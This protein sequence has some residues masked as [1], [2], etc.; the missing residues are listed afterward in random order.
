MLGGASSSSS[1]SSSL[2]GSDLPSLCRH[3]SQERLYVNAEKKQLKVGS[4][5]RGHFSVPL[6]HLPLIKVIPTQEIYWIFLLSH[7][8]HSF[9]THQ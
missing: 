8:S 2:G 1:S 6:H 4:V 5:K 9:I 3:L 7:Y